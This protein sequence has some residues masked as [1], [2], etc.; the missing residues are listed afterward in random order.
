VA[1]AA[2][3][4]ITPI[5]SMVE[6]GLRSDPS[7]RFTL[8]YGNQKVD[9]ILFNERLQ[10][11]KDTYPAR[12]SLIHILS[13]Q[14]QDVPLLNG[15]MDTAKV[16]ELLQTLLPVAD[17]DEVFICGPEGM[18]DSTE[19]AL[20]AA[21][22]AQEKIH[23][24]RFVSAGSTAPGTPRPVATAGASASLQTA[25]VTLD[26]VIDGKTHSMG[27]QTTDKLLDVALAAGLDLPYSCKGGV[28]CTCRGRIM[29]GKVAMEKNFT[30]EKWEVDKG[31]V[32]TC[33]ARPL[34]PRVVV[35]YDER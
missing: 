33:Q 34:T 30:L 8:V 18:I 26:V 31:F 19:Q 14:S 6:S 24:E 35:S 2:G 32:L 3:S 5:L 10:D 15:R 29:E 27:M 12:L 25:P 22:L 21:G 11:L 16:T 23:T 17:I 4:G 1:F 13:R 7:A 20:L 9:S 28:C